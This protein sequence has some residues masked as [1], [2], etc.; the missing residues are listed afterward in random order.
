[1][2]SK[3]GRVMGL[4]NNAKK[5]VRI[6]IVIMLIG[7]AMIIAGIVIDDYNFYWM[8]F[9]GAILFV[10]FLICFFMFISQA[11]RLDGMFRGI[12]LLA[13]WGFEEN[14]RLQKAEEEFFQRKSQNKVML[15]I[16]AAFFIVIGGLFAVFGFDDIEDAMFFI[17]LM[18]GILAFISLVALLAP[19]ARYRK[20]KQ[21]VPDVFVGPYSAW[22]MGE[23]VQ[24]KAPMTKITSVQ[25]TK[26][27]EDNYT[28]TVNFFIW[29]RY[30]PQPHTCRIPVPKGAE[31][32]AEIV[33]SDIANINNVQFMNEIG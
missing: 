6:S 24:W 19:G 17:L 11:K 30:G 27:R 32:E 26:D 21:A 28:I 7:I 20:M 22:V 14:E 31:T 33:A 25:Y 10:T 5:W 13:H 1:M 23:Y 3:G 4:Q 18:L 15:L 2:V 29:Q 16:I 12:D 8:I 9:V